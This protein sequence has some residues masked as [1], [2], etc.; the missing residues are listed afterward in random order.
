MSDTVI[1]SLAPVAADCPRVIPE[2]L[3]QEILASVEHGAAIVHLHV[4][5]KQGRLTPDTTDFQATIDDVMRH[6]DLIIQASTGGV[7]AMSIAERCAP[8]EISG[9]GDGSAPGVGAACQKMTDTCQRVPD[10]A[11][12]DA[13]KRREREARATLMF[14]RAE[15]KDRNEVDYERVQRIVT[16]STCG[17]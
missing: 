1:I 9:I 17:G 5:D 12:C 13:W 11:A 10:G 15:D 16:E 7:S 4:R 3:A 6:S 8:L 2:E 14:G